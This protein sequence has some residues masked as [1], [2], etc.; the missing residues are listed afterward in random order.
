MSA[1]SPAF[2]PS[3][4][5]APGKYVAFV[6]GTSN[7]PCNVDADCP[8]SILCFAA[9]KTTWAEENTC[10]CWPGVHRGSMCESFTPLGQTFVAVTALVIIVAGVTLSLIHI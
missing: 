8:A 7:W 3:P 10:A 2:A 5:G 4:S 1:D 9:N 6:N